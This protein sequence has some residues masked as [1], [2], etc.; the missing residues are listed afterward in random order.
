LRI[1]E[2]SELTTF[3]ILNRKMPDSRIYYLLHI[4]PSKFDRAR[5]IPIGDGLGRVLAEII[6][7]VKRFYN[8]E[9]VPEADRLLALWTPGG[10]PSRR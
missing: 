6:R 4:K 5:V 3:D 2:A 9:S 8:S 7:Y 1:E 10:K